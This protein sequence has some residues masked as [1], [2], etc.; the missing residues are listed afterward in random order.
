MAEIHL[1]VESYVDHDHFSNHVDPARATRVVGVHA[2]P[3]PHLGKQHSGESD[4]KLTR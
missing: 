1:V 2:T 4:K 3:E